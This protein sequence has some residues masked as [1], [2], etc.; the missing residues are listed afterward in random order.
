MIRQAQ[1]TVQGSVTNKWA[2]H[3]PRKLCLGLHFWDQVLKGNP[4][5]IYT[6]E[7]FDLY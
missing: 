5:E 4:C 1:K 7:M 2:I 6:R 3:S